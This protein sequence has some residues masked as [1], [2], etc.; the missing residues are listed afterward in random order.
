MSI[1]VFSH[2]YTKCND[3]IIVYPFDGPYPTSWSLTTATV[4]VN[5]VALPMLVLGS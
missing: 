1:E 4:I 3:E 5:R 2:T